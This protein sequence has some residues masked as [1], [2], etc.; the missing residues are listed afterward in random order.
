MGE[1]ARTGIAPWLEGLG[2]GQYAQVFIDQ[3]IDLDTLPRLSND[4]LRELGVRLGHRKPLLAAIAALDRAPARPNGLPQSEATPSPS[5]AIERRQLT[6]LL[7]DLVGSTEL[8]SRLDP[9]DLRELMMLYQ[10]TCADVVS[11]HDGFIAQYRGD[12]IM[13][14]FGYPLANED[15]AERAVRAGIELMREIAELDGP[16]GTKIEARIGIAT[17]LAVVGGVV[18]QGASEH[19]AVAGQVPNLAARI[20]AFA[21]PGTVALAESTQRLVGHVF[22]YEDLGLQRFKGIDRDVRVW[23]A[24]GEGD[25]DVRYEALRSSGAGLFVNRDK[26]TAFLTER[27]QDAVQGRGQVVLLSGEAG[28]GKSSVLRRLTDRVAGPDMYRI[29][30]QCSP[31]HMD[32]PLYP[33][34]MHLRRAAHFAPADAPSV[35]LAKIEKILPAESLLEGAPL[36]AALL[37]VPAGERYPPSSLPPDRQKALTLQLLVDQ[38]VRL[39]RRK[40]VLLQFEDAHWMDPTTEELSWQLVDLLR[41]HRVLVI[42]T[43][44]PE[45]QPG[46]TD[47]PHVSTMPLGRLEALHVHD[48]IGRI[49]GGKRLPGVVTDHILSKTDGVPLFVEELTKSVLESGMLS[50]A[51]DGYVLDEPLRSLAI[52]S[53]LQDSLMARLDRLGPTKAV[54]QVGAAIGRKFSFAMLASVTGHA[55]HDMS[56][57]LDGLVAAELINGRGTPP[58]AEYTFK[59]ALVQDAAYESLL[60][61][62]RKSLHGRIAHAIETGF[63]DVVETEPEA[64]AHHWTRAEVADKAARYWL[65]AGQRA[66][67]RSANV[68]AIRHLANGIRLLDRV[69]DEADRAWLDFNLNLSLGQACYMV[70]G[71]AA[72]ET[73]KA[74]TRAQ[75]LVEAVSDPEERYALLYGIFSC[76]HFAARFALAEEPAQR[77]LALATRDG[78]AGHMCQAHRMLGYIRFFSG[79]LT[80]ALD[81]FRQLACLYEPD[82][83]AHLAFRYGADSR[84]AAQGFQAIIDAVAGRPESAVAMISANIAYSQQL[85]HPTTL[86]WTLAARGYVDFL[87]RDV[88]GCLQITTEG[89]RYCEQNSVGAWAVHCRIFNAWARAHLSRPEGCEEEI[90]AAIADAATRTALGLP[91]FR[92]LL[93]EVLLATGRPEEATR[94]SEVALAQIA[95]TDQYF[96]EPV[97]HH[98]RGK[99]VLALPPYDRDEA[100][101]CFRRS[102]EA[103]RRCGAKLLELRAVTSLAQLA[104][105]TDQA[106]ARQEV[107]RLYGEFQEGFAT[108]DLQTA[109]ELL[110][111]PSQAE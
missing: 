94:E 6:V 79:D 40:P 45:Y 24:L 13:V 88:P 21:E 56:E 102:L 100:R 73:V 105:G 26:E 98:I 42:I 78:D 64:L 109:R 30:L 4:D 76:Y 16:V 35:K 20:Q 46:W 22:D 55:Q 93:A 89:F 108:A 17:G 15:A 29:R 5:A 28:I 85:G 33:L 90:R 18:G 7:C 87:I 67:A 1:T 92:G 63:P 47:R 51:D 106:A 72:A 12:G 107:A 34:I 71:P 104:T 23:K 14:Y 59:H 75:E 58:A 62:Q 31:R 49:A 60:H 69:S 10:T 91:L 86:G 95:A 32:T 52:P 37:S 54:A 83:H 57:A 96:F 110:A 43:G 9:E 99:C 38:F 53:T 65:K 25:H 44:R 68:E 101:A 103:A 70:K 39:T 82:K 36:L 74:Y 97:L 41:D 61:M 48:L 11:R 8:S 111:T 80:G 19:T 50:D 2:L 84:A 27:W 3:A 81:H 77:A 66:L